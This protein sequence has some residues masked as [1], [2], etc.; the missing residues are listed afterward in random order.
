MRCTASRGV[1]ST[2]TL[3]LGLLSAQK[4]VL[5][6]NVPKLLTTQGTDSTLGDKSGSLVEVCSLPSYLGKAGCGDQ[7][8]C[9]RAPLKL[10]LTRN[11][12]RISPS[13][14]NT[15]IKNRR[16]AWIL[17]P[18]LRWG[19]RD[20]GTPSPPPRT[21]ALGVGLPRAT[22]RIPGEARTMI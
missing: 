20:R 21:T 8:T 1:C 13:T 16:R 3:Q 14:L 7:R 10:S 22:S 12:Q 17:H 4:C 11:M 6:Q 2:N 15:E 9:P 18:L 5:P 19:A